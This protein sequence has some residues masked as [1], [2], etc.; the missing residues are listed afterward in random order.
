MA[1]VINKYLDGSIFIR[2]ENASMLIDNNH[3]FHKEAFEA[4]RIGNI[5]RLIEMIT[6]NKKAVDIR[7]VMSDNPLTKK[8]PSNTFRTQSSVFIRDSKGRFAKKVSQPVRDSKGRFVKGAV[9]QKR[10]SKGRFI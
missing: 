3:P 1:T 4:H 6:G 8:I 9:G 2:H 7:S 10:D 5:D